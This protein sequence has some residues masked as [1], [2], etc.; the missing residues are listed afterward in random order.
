MSSIVVQIM[1]ITLFL[2]LGALLYLYVGSQGVSVERGDDLF[3]YVAIEC[4]LPA[5]AGVLFLLGLVASTYSSAG[6]AL[7]ALTTSFTIDI[8]KLRKRYDVDTEE[9]GNVVARYR[10]WVHLFVALVMAVIIIGFERWSEGGAITLI[11]TMA[12][13]TYG[14]LLA[15]F[16][17]GLMT[18]CSLRSWTIPVISIAAPI[19]SYVIASHS[20]VWF[21]GYEF[22]YEIL[23]LNAAIAFAGLYFTSYNTKK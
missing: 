1:V 19:L 7:T 3:G 17:F 21:G 10:R 15:L 2:S 13:Y 16:S 5:V 18:Q 12:S 23:I 8:L 9:G 6:S 22:S 20:K 14:P 4:G 11:F